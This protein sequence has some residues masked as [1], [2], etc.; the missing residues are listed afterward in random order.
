MNSPTEWKE[1]ESFIQKVEADGNFYLDSSYNTVVS[2]LATLGNPHLKLPPVIHIAGTNGKGSTLAT[3]RALCQASGLKTSCFTSPELIYF[4]ERIELANNLITNQQLNYY[5]EKCT[6]HLKHSIKFQQFTALPALCAF[7]DTQAD[8]VLLEAIIGGRLD[9]TNVVPVPACT[10]LTPISMDHPKDLGPNLRCIADHKA[11]IMRSGV[12]VIISP[13]TKEVMEIYK[14]ESRKLSAPIYVCGKEWDYKITKTGMQFRWYDQKY[15]FAKPILYGTHQFMNAGIALATAFATNMHNKNIKI[16]VSTQNVEKAFKSVSH[17]G[18]LQKLPQGNLLK[19]ITGNVEIWVDGATN[20]QGAEILA[21]EIK[22]WQNTDPEKPVYLIY[23]TYIS[24][25]P[26]FWFK[27]LGD[28][29]VPVYTFN[30]LYKDSLEDLYTADQIYQSLYG[31]DL[32]VN[33][34]ENLQSAIQQITKQSPNCKILIAGSFKIV[35][36]AL[37]QNSG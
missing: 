33:V 13:Q 29:Q 5:F 4:N 36:H 23:S 24:K 14:T 17:P 10:V 3:L 2:C 30:F 6:K 9:A 34:V 25:D 11:G 31:L 20:L 8:L 27:G 1:L 35:K 7:A 22:K 16:D 26:K 18:R 19:D 21:T 28:I 15:E 32:D 12:P 37:V